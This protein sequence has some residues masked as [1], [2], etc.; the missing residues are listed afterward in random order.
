MKVY[1]GKRLD[2]GTEITVNGKPLRHVVRHSPTGMEWGYGGSGPADLALSILTD[3][4]N[5]PEVERLYGSFKWEIVA[6]LPRENW[7][8]TEEQIREWADKKLACSPF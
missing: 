3:C 7:E 2:G 4:F 5:V 1:R 6:G 8:L